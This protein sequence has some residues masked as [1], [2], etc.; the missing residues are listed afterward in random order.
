MNSLLIQIKARAMDDLIR[1]SLLDLSKYCFAAVTV[2]DTRME[3]DS[4]E[5]D[6]SGDMV[7]T[8]PKEACLRGRPYFISDFGPN[9]VSNLTYIWLSTL[10]NKMI[11]LHCG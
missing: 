5:Q 1:R 6:G 8:L 9:Y 10:R 11:V 3:L 7:R 4:M 2:I